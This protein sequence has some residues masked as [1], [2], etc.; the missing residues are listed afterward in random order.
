MASIGIE[1]KEN[2][3][4]MSQTVQSVV[5]RGSDVDYSI[6][7]KRRASKSKVISSSFKRFLTF[8]KLQGSTDDEENAK[9]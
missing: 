5:S 7:L 9:D 4:R 8:N 2:R 3:K 1:P 6:S